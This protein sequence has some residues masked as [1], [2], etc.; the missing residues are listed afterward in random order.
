MQEP[1]FSFITLEKFKFTISW[2]TNFLQ[3]KDICCNNVTVSLT[4]F[5]NNVRSIWK[6]RLLQKG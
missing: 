2:K 1:T 6:S 3:E 5:Y 4:I